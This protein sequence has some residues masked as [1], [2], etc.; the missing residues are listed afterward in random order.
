VRLSG[1]IMSL[2]FLLH[3]VPLLLYLPSG[4]HSC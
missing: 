3:V 1:E 4:K 2:I